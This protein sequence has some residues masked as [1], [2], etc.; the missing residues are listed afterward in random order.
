MASQVA[1]NRPKTAQIRV[2]LV[3][4]LAAPTLATTLTVYSTLAPEILK[5]IVAL[6]LP[7]V[8]PE[9]VLVVVS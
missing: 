8:P 2:K 7:S 6:P 5:L 3:I 1:S 9:S 4:Q